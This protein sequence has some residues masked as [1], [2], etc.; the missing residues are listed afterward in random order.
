MNTKEILTVANWPTDFVV[1]DLVW[2]RQKNEKDSCN[3]I[4]GENYVESWGQ[5]YNN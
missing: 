4:F 3:V 1:I 2:V 5:N